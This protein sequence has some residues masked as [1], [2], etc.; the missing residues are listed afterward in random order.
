MRASELYELMDK[1]LDWEEID[2]EPQFAIAGFDIQGKQYTV[3]IHV[4]DT[5]N[6]IANVSF[7]LGK[8]GSD[9][10]I[11]RMNQTGTGDPFLVYGTVID[12][13]LT[14]VKKLDLK[15]ITFSANSASKTKL[16]SKLATRIASKLGWS[17]DANRN[18]FE[19]HQPLA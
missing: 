1:P 13:L 3:I 7:S 17:V 14:Y 8:P 2:F 10:M 12:I 18:E 9:R 6:H 15:G 5:E 4:H 11:G 16:Y 19:L